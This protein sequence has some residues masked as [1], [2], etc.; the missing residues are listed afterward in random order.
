MNNYS[1][2]IP[3]SKEDDSYIEHLQKCPIDDIKP[4]IPQLLEWLQ[5]GNWPQARI[6]AKYFE[7]YIKEIQEEIIAILHTNDSVWKYWVLRLVLHSH[8]FPGSIMAEIQR[9]AEKPTDTETDEGIYEVA[10]EII[11]AH[12]L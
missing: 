9:I 6:I 8:T 7:P 4:A 5:D 1:H 10:L 2:I 11:A 12:K 3:Q